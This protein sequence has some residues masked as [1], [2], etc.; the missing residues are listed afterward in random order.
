M[1]L[2]NAPLSS[3]FF[4]KKILNLCH[5]I[6]FLALK[7]IL[8]LMQ[9]VY[10]RFMKKLSGEK[11]LVKLIDLNSYKIVLILLAKAAAI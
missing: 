9:L 7:K 1:L 3:R 8:V 5:I 6:K 4:W 10:H 11:D 2:T